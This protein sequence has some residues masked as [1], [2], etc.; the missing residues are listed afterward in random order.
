MRGIS[1]AAQSVWAKSTDGEGRWLPLHQHLDDTADVMGHLLGHWVPPA[2]VEAAAAGS[3]M[4]AEQ[5][6]RV[7]QFL[8]GVH[9]IGKATPA[10]ACM[11]VLLADRM[12]SHGLVGF[13]RQELGAERREAHHALTGHILLRDWLV[14]E[15]GMARP[16]ASTWAVVVGGHHGMPPTETV[17]GAM[18]PASHRHLIGDGAWTAVRHELMA[19]QWLRFGLD[20]QQLRPLSQPAQVLLMGLVIV[21]DWIAS[22]EW[23]FP[24]DELDERRLARGMSRLRL[25]A[26]WHAQH[27][28][29]EVE[30]LFSQR[31][32]FPPGA[33]PRPTQ[34]AAAEMAWTVSGPGLMIIEA[35][36]GEGKT[37]AALAAAEVLA[38]RFGLGGIFV[39]LPT[40]ATTDAMFARMV[41]WLEHL[42]GPDLQVGASVSLAHGKAALNRQFRGMAPGARPRQVDAD[43]ATGGRGSPRVQ[44]HA[45]LTGR[46]KAA[47]ATVVVGTIDQLL[48]SALKSRH[49]AMRMTGLM[50]K[51]VVVDEVHA[52]DTW[53]SS[54]LDRVLAW[55]GAAKVPVL[56]LSATLP[57][58]RRAALLRAYAGGVEP[59]ADEGLAYP[60]VS[61]TAP[62]GPVHSAAVE[63]SGRCTDVTLEI[64]EE[65]PASL[66]AGVGEAIRDGGCALVVRNTVGRAREAAAALREALGHDLVTLVHSR[67][68]AYDRARKDEW[69]L[70]RFGSPRRLAESGGTRPDRHV[71]V[72]TQ[73]VEQSLD[74]DFDVLFTDLAPVDLV[75]Q[76][77]GRMHRHA[78]RG[79]PPRLVTPKCYLTGVT[80]TEAAPEFPK[81]SVA[82][83]QAYPLL[84]AAAVLTPRLGGKVRLPA[85]IPVLVQAAYGDDLEF[86][87]G[88]RESALVA[89]DAAAARR[90][91]QMR[92][93]QVF[94]IRPP[95]RG[96][97]RDWGDGT[98]GDVEETVGGRAAVRD[99]A[100]ELECV[101]VCVDERGAWRTPDWLDPEDAWADVPTEAC[102]TDEVAEAVARCSIRLPQELA[103]ADIEE[104]LWQQTPLT[105]E[106]APALYRWPVLPM[107]RLEGDIWC[108]RLQAA[109]ASYVVTYST[110]DGL[111]VTHAG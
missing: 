85:D 108:A 26:P 50:G 87:D 73:V 103:N 36:M 100:A 18:S 48:F 60:L 81:G 69:L 91:K 32:T 29:R 78:G 107:H 61:V 22:N 92:G 10:F 51:V 64:L 58:R 2:A 40:Q 49:L 23:L 111:E 89:K 45:W 71:V 72:A 52:Y 86:P 53:M 1:E 41:D 99:G 76:R 84:A 57:A 46:K 47:L 19:A 88:W 104:L 79:R 37:E 24:Y 6:A 56:L 12:A 43:V 5:F 62:G 54:Y 42:P 105:W 67:F 11:D 82:V 70:D 97:I 35:P 66:V 44:T 34:E 96:A 102:P 59:P 25:P 8:G 4:P 68:L 31:F 93:A 95:G 21:A 13:G 65:D 39:A 9:D 77:I 110:T 16:D 98:A 55:L 74:V 90:K 75:L 15:Q 80:L 94:Q 27:T 20:G 106:N 3:G 109:G 33:T 63:A 83:Y 30:R 38:H 17:L 28:P 14:K 101:V 7:A